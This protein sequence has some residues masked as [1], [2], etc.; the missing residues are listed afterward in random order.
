MGTQVMKST[1]ASAPVL[2]GEVNSL[3]LLLKACLVDGY[4][5]HASLGWTQAFT[6]T[7][8]AAFQAGEGL[9]HYFRLN[10]SG[11]GTGGA[12]E[13]LIRGFVAMTDVDT[14]TDPFPSDAQSALTEDSLIARKSVTADAT[15][16]AWVVVADERTC[17]VFVKTG[18]NA[19]NYLAFAFGEFYSFLPSDAYSSFLVAR[20]TE[21]SGTIT[22]DNLDRLIITINIAVQ[23]HYFPR[24]Y[25]QLGTSVQF[26]KHGDVAKSNS[27][28]FTVGIIPLYNPEDGGLYVSRLWISDSTTL[29]ANNIRGVFRGLW[30]CLHPVASVNDLDTF[31]GVGDLAGK[32]FLL[33]KTGGNGG[34]YT[35]ETSD[36]EVS[37]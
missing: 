37:P 20:T 23:G 2:T 11:A 17:Y 4:G 1:D 8:K 14:G 12:K 33:L 29:P 25:T 5:V 16:R 24:G 31:N 6:G 19:N 26:G 34:I 3:R 32:T 21:N 7:D 30:H 10:D 35:L 9:Q 22:N 13:A 27:S 36:W 15:A 18:D 28:T